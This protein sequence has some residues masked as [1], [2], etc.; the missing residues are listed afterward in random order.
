MKLPALLAD[1]A[2]VAGIEAAR[3]VARARGGTVVYFPSAN[4]INGGGG[5]WLVEAVGETT[6]LQISAIFPM[7]QAVSIP[8][9]L[10]GDRRRLKVAELTRE[11]RG[12]NDIARAIG[13]T[14][15]SVFRYRQR[16][17]KEGLL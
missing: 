15:R 8:L 5:R 16:L 12:V 10:D 11:G 7:G 1:I 3:S 2:N 6:A 13:C 17:K 9:W 14:T 4:T